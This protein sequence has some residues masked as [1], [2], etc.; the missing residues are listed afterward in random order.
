MVLYNDSRFS[1]CSHHRNR[2]LVPV[3]Q[4]ESGIEGDNVACRPVSN[5]I[6]AITPLCPR[7]SP[8]SYT[9]ALTDNRSSLFLLS[10]ASL[11]LFTQ[12]CRSPFPRLCIRRYEF[13]LL[14][15]FSQQ[16][17]SNGVLAWKPQSAAVHQRAGQRCW[18]Y[19]F[20]T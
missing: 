2:I 16:F 3:V 15:F 5:Y 20:F 11:T 19:S 17:L 12:L 10:R 18:N 13:F 1:H 7:P 9:Y 6:Q 4:A 8:K 14:L